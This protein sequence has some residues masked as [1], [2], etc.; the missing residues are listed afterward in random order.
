MSFAK[1]MK[2]VLCS[3]EQP[4][5]PWLRSCPLC[6]SF[7]Y[8]M[9]YDLGALSNHLDRDAVAKRPPQ[10]LIK[11][12]EFLPIEDPSKI[13]SLGE[14]E[15][16]LIPCSRL[17]KEIGIRELY[18]KDETAHATASYKDRSLAV[19]TTSAVEAGAK[20]VAIASTGNAGAATAA[21]A[22]RADLRCRVFVPSTANREKLIQI[23]V[24][25]GRVIQVEGGFHDAVKLYLE[26]MERFGWYPTG[27][28]N[29]FRWE[30]D[31]TLAY[32]IAQ[33]FD[34]KGP[35]RVICPTGSGQF[36]SRVFKGFSELNKLDWIEEVPRMTAV[37]AE[38]TNAIERAF[39]EKKSRADPVEGEPT[40]ASGIAVADPMEF[41][42]TALK[43]L[44]QSG[45]AIVSLNEEEILESQR[46]L[47]RTVG[48]FA[49]P[50]GAVG[51]KGLMKLKEQGEI[52]GEEVVVVIVTGHGL[53]DYGLARKLV[54]DNVLNITDFAELKKTVTEWET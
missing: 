7:L 32:E 29:Q 44:Q 52:G 11:W 51:I 22:A 31:K 47:A 6:G 38:A 28:G 33:A 15:T 8:D 20:T 4:V 41:G 21:F 34:W 42:R 50:A 40:I 37:Q 43:A 16:F 35:D 1:H 48:I 45:G 46:I 25:G 3:S 14:R 24:H 13:V 54:D 39:R 2:C 19:A 53:K 17:A 10:I 36:I 18:L 49:E 5:D 30:G 12:L 9:Q 27:I 26:A 23:M